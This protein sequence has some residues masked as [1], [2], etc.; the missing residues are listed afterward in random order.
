MQ[1]PLS[2]IYD[3][4][5]PLCASTMQKGLA[6]KMQKGLALKMQKG[7]ALKMQK[8]LVLKMHTKV[9]VHRSYTKG[10]RN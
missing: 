4:L 8:G 9:V 5:R 2:C 7:L 1:T 6:L 10:V 3:A